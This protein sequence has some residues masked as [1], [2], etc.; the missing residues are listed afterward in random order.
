MGEGARDLA[1]PVVGSDKRMIHDEDEIEKGV[2]AMMKRTQ[3]AAAVIGLMLVS[4]GLAR[5]QTSYIPE[6]GMNLFFEAVSTQDMWT[7]ESLLD[8]YP[9]LVWAARS[10]DGKTGLHVA[11]MNGKFR[12][13]KLLLERGADPDAK[14]MHGKTTLYYAWKTP[15][16][17]FVRLIRQHGGTYYGRIEARG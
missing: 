2:S 7:L 4:G 13:A 1:D 12:S 16:P 8:Q 11:V 14:D 15:Y 6:E 9:S 5:A 17:G 3:I 10:D